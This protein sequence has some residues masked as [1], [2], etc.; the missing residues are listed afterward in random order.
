MQCV[1][2]SVCYLTE[3]HPKKV[4]KIQTMA[5]NPGLKLERMLV[6]KSGNSALARGSEGEGES[7]E[8][9]E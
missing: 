2:G 6:V 5:T 3:K 4:A 7:E 1:D 8:S 9:D